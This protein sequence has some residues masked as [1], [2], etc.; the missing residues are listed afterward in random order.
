MSGHGVVKLIDLTDIGGTPQFLAFPVLKTL[1]LA[2][3]SATRHTK[4]MMQKRFRGEGLFLIH[5]SP[6]QWSHSG[7]CKDSY[8]MQICCNW[9]VSVNLF[10][11]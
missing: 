8:S 10:C 6:T 9:P 1:F 3:F 5:V 11:F 7:D 2:N 4:L